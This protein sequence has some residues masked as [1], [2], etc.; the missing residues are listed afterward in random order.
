MTAYPH[1]SGGQS[2]TSVGFETTRPLADSWFEALLESAPDA[3]LIVDASGA[4]VVANSQAERLF[5]Y[6]RSELIGEA[7]E[8][9]VPE[10][11]R[12]LHAEHRDHYNNNP[13]VR[14]MGHGMDA[15]LM[16]RRKDGSIF[17][18]EISLSALW[19]AEG[20]LVTSVIRD[21]SERKRIEEQLE[22]QVQHRT[23][24]LNALLGLSTT[25]L[26]ERDI[27][28]IL[29]H[30]LQH[31]MLLVPEAQQG[32]IYLYDRAEHTLVLRASTHP[33]LVLGSTVAVNIGLCGRAFRSGHI[34]AASSVTEYAAALPPMQGDEYTQMLEALGL[35]QL[36]SGALVIPLLAHNEAL[37]VLRLLRHTG[38]GPFASEARPTL[39]L[40]ANLTATA[41]TEAHSHYTADRL[42]T[43]VARLEDQQRE[44]TA[45]LDSAEAG[46]L[47]AARLAAV[48]QLA[49]SVAHEINNPLYAARN[50]LFLLEQ[51]LPD[52]LQG[53]PYLTI[54]QQ[55]LARIA[56]IIERMRDFYRPD[57]G[58]FAPCDLNQLLEHTLAV[59]VLNARHKAI[60]VQFA[61]NTTLP[62][63][64]G[65]AD[66]L[67]QV[68]LNLVINALD[69]MPDGGTLSVRTAF[70]PT[71][72]LV[73]VA[74]T[75]I[76]IP[77]DIRPRLFEPFYTTKTNGTGL[78]LS[79]SAHIVTQHGGQIEVE[80][81]PGKGTI[82]R[83]VLPHE[84][85]ELPS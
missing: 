45:R 48:G 77:D 21:V 46:M 34:Q 71:V 50:S 73:E 67:R 28:A 66:Q 65:N 7:V 75:G 53:T 15:E 72:V 39:G 82:F 56:G 9:L 22:R 85:R 17:P 10:A 2:L 78:G 64:Q 35:N 26:A 55:E 58:E 24:H 1:G 16:A 43:Q 74:D 8:V 6:D 49:A 5:G 59:A 47:Q 23:A 61:P 11:Q 79:I 13:H 41:I 38:E 70:G 37:G 18:V 84:A 31:A 29:Q 76:G 83:V 30:A 57:R 63:I 62:S 54:L 60:S 52:D 4:I 27:D 20:L 19:T 80:T 32:A 69:A 40:L 12:R 33:S 44:L 51:D 68:F 42:T 25:L 81:N 36:P 3:I 14:P